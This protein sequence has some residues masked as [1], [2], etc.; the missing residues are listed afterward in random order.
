M[1]NKDLDIST[2]LLVKKTSKLSAKK[3]SLAVKTYNKIFNFYFQLYRENLSNYNRQ[4]KVK[5]FK[6]IKLI[7]YNQEIFNQSLYEGN[8]CAEQYL[9]SLDDLLQTVE[10]QF[11][12]LYSEL[13]LFISKIDNKKEV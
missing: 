11:G 7:K 10:E 2:N 9:E 13:E 6:L 3:L 12:N 8:D 1:V 4:L 5:L